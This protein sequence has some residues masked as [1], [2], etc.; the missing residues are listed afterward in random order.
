M[1]KPKRVIRPVEK[2][3]SIPED[4][5]LRIDLELYSG[6]EQRVPHGAWSKLVTSLLAAH[7]VRLD[8]N[9]EVSN[10]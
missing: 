6:L 7:I 4:I 3:I 1:P 8:S 10:G 2:K 9:R 5:V